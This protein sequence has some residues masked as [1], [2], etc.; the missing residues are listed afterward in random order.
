[1]KIFMDTANVEEIRELSEW[2]IVYGV[3][4]NPSLIA[5]TGRS[6]DDVIKEICHIIDGPISAEVISTDCAGMVEEARKLA[7]IAPNVVIKVPCI[8]EGLKA[9]KILSA[10][11]IAT[12]VTLI[13]SLS[14]A[15]LAAS[16]GANYV[17]PFI[18]RLD[19]IG[20]D[21]IKLVENMVSV[22]KKYEF[23]TEIIAASIRDLEHVNRVMLAGADIA[24][25]PTK[26]IREMI[27][28]KLTDAG[29][30]RFLLD[31]ENS[32]K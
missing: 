28:H 4:T 24:T 31:Y 19:D 22:F 27:E 18:G 26:I 17:S 10:E 9:V 5:K 11:C 2:G 8:V 6:Q 29:L 14:Q 21:G 12:N 1:M 15:L 23:D 16:A 20:E 32:K 25:I 13:F 7:K 3:T 30:K